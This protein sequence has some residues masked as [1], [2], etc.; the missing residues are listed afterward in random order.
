MP[1]TGGPDQR[2]SMPVKCNMNG[3]KEI[4]PVLYA[5]AY[6]PPNIQRDPRPIAQMMIGGAQLD[7]AAQSAFC[8]SSPVFVPRGDLGGWVTTRDF[9]WIAGRK[10]SLKLAVQ[11]VI[12]FSFFAL[13]PRLLSSRHCTACVLGSLTAAA[14]GTESA[15]SSNTHI[16]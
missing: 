1:P 13:F 8:S 3:S 14:T 2:F 16:N 15:L 10:C 9:W 11:L 6:G 4:E 5:R 7:A 12:K